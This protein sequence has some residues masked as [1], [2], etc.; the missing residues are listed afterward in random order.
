M[1]HIENK[2]LIYL[3]ISFVVTEET[4]DRKMEKR[5]KLDKK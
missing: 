4:I 5:K 3:P 2:T 1:Q